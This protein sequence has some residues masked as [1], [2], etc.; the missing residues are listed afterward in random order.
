MSGMNNNDT[1]SSGDEVVRG[2]HLYEWVMRPFYVMVVFRLR[3]S[4]SA[5][6]V[7]PTGEACT[8]DS[9]HD[10]FVVRA[11]SG[12]AD[13]VQ[14]RYDAAS[15]AIVDSDSPATAKFV[16]K[17]RS[18]SVTF[19]SG[20]SVT[21]WED[22][23]QFVSTLKRND[24]E[25][26]LFYDVFPMEGGLSDVIFSVNHAI[27]DGKCLTFV[28]REFMSY[29]NDIVMQMHSTVPSTS[30]IIDKIPFLNPVEAAP[31]PDCSEGRS[32]PTSHELAPLPVE[33]LSLA[34]YR[35]VYQ[36]LDSTL[37]VKL[38][39]VAKLRGV[40]MQAAIMVATLKALSSILTDRSQPLPH[41]FVSM[42]PCIFRKF[43]NPPM[44]DNCLTLASAPLFWGC[45]HTGTEGL[46]ELASKHSGFLNQELKEEHYW[47]LKAMIEGKN[48]NWSL[49]AG[50]NVSNIG[51]ISVP[52]F[53][54]LGATDPRPTVVL[55]G[56]WLRTTLNREH[57]TGE[58]FG[59][60]LHFY[61][62]GGPHP[63]LNATTTYSHPAYQPDTMQQ[64]LN[65]TFQ[66][67]VEMA[68]N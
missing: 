44:D 10:D 54:S 58:P 65:L 57:R 5:S 59:Y 46:W 34:K 20:W 48:K 35:S 18:P 63:Q 43:L 39:Q 55:E 8:A 11:V 28:Y 23:A 16:R 33:D 24:A 37:T 67:L 42:V 22:K 41:Y 45:E 36:Q 12:A 27:S 50:L 26:L 51:L 15:F 40:S 6:T 32:L 49:K 29:L 47:H 17:S 53:Q 64:L 4:A 31:T 3:I 66:N 13:L 9:R 60:M 21:S 56:L 1:E 19:H 62:I 61:T 2:M 7:A 30:R 25:C 14:R 68:T 38:L 52:E